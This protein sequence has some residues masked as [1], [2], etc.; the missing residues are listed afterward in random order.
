MDILYK[1]YAPVVKNI[2]IWGQ[3]IFIRR[4]LHFVDN[5]HAKKNTDP[6]YYPLSNLNGIMKHIMTHMKVTWTAC[7]CINIDESMIKYMGVQMAFLI[8]YIPNKSINH[9]IK[10]LLVAV[11][12]QIYYFLLKYI[13][14]KTLKLLLLQR[15][16]L[17]SIL[18]KV[19]I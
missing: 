13:L 6:G 14:V 12:P 19:H 2:I 9:G 8:Q 1:I 17:L 18:L 3:F 16:M 11:L 4:F 10:V 7:Q 5:K 15:N